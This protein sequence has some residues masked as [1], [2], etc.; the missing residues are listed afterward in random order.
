ML[1][2]EAEGVK[3]ED[4]WNPPPRYVSWKGGVRTELLDTEETWVRG[5]T[6]T[7]RVNL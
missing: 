3:G 1:D 6:T 2:A 5:P 7:A 4:Q